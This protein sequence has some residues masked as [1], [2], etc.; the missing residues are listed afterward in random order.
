MSQLDV[1]VFLDESGKREKPSLMGGLSIP[2]CI[3]ERR[4]FSELSSAIAE[5]ALHWARYNGDS[6]ERK[7]IS[8][9]LG[10]LCRFESMIKFNVIQYNQSVLEQNASLDFGQS[11]LA[12]LTIYTKFPERII[13]GLLRKYGKHIRLSADIIIEEASEYECYHLNEKLLEQLNVQS[14]YRG[15]RFHIHSSTFRPKGYEVGLELTDILLGIIRAIMKNDA[16]AQ[17]RSKRA[18]N[19]LIVTLL[20]DSAFHRLLANIKYFEWSDSQDLRE[21]DFS[22][23]LQAFLAKHHD[24]WLNPTR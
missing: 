22:G 8:R 4:E 6:K 16:V 12:D 9:A 21:I 18:K 5:T 7:L 3:Y 23:Y 20:Q 14:L 13:Y 19:Q 11:P 10:S 17:S 2:R 24:L 1:I 15:E